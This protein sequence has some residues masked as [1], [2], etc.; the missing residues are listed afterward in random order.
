MQQAVNLEFDGRTAEA[1][2]LLEEHRA[3]SEMHTEE[4]LSHFFGL[5]RSK[6]L[7]P[8]DLENGVKNGAGRKKKAT[9]TKPVSTGSRGNR[10]EST[11]GRPAN[12]LD[13]V[14]E[15]TATAVLLQLQGKVQRLLSMRSSK[16]VEKAKE[17][18]K[19]VARLREELKE[20]IAVLEGR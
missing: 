17:A 3:D 12:I 9:R 2:R 5:R 19:R 11:P 1:V 10:R 20:A 16:D 15:G 7:G 18:L 4:Y 6:G 14:D 8:Y 13:M